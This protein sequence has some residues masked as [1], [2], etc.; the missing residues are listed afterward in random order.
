MKLVLEHDDFPAVS[1]LTPELL[2]DHMYGFA[3]YLKRVPDGRVTAVLN[4][5]GG[6]HQL[7]VTVEI[8]E[9]DKS[10]LP[11]RGPGGKFVKAEPVLTGPRLQ[12]TDDLFD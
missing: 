7:P 4:Y 6:N 10:N 9:P 8:A 12:N 5:R 2:T 3:V 1:G 11:K